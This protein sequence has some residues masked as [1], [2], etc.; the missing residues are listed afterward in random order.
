MDRVVK[1]GLLGAILL[2][3]L[4][5]SP[6]LS[7]A[8]EPWPLVADPLIWMPGSQPVDRLKLT[9]AEQCLKCH[10]DFSPAS[11]PGFAWRGSMMAQA[12]RD[13]LMWAALTVA[14]QDAIWALGNPNAADLCLRCHFP[15]GWLAGRTS[16]SNGSALTGND[17]D[18]ISC[19]LCH[20]MWDP[21]FATAEQASPACDEADPGSA[22]AARL[23]LAADAVEAKKIQLF[24]PADFYLDN[25]PK[26]PASYRENGSGQFYIS[27]N[28]AKRGGVIDAKVA[29]E[30]GHTTLY[31]RYHKSRNFCATCHDVSNSALA[32]LGLSDLPDLSQGEDLLSEQY[33][34][35]NYF[36]I[37]RTFSEFMLSAYGRGR[38]AATNQEF[39]TQGTTDIAWAASCQDCHMPQVSG[40]NANA[41]G[42][43]PVQSKKQ[44]NSG[45]AR[46]ELSGGNSWLPRILASLDPAGPIFDRRNLELLG[47]GPDR[48]TLD[49]RQGLGL[50]GESS[51]LL[52]ASERA[53]EQLRVAA[54]IKE[55]QY[56]PETGALSLRIQNNTGHKLLT[57]FPEGRRMF[58]NLKTYRQGR[59]I[60]EINPYSM[61]AGTLKGLPDAA[62]SPPL[63]KTERYLDELVY[64]VHLRSELT[65]EEQTSHVL[66]AS[67]RSKD[68]RIPPKG[69]D[70]A[71]AATRLSEPVWQGKSATAYFSAA[72]YSGGYDQLQ[73]QLPVGADRVQI[74][75]YYQGVSREYIEFLRDEI[76]GTAGSLRLD[77]KGKN[78]AGGSET[79]TVQ[80]DPFFA[81][82][83]G[84]GDSIWELWHHNHGLTGDRS[85]LPG[86]APLLM[87]QAEW[88]P[89]RSVDGKKRQVQAKD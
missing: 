25:Q 45:P 5:F 26:Y 30:S 50:K 83:K 38:G 75:L 19:D 21:F 82:L 28:T 41:A 3:T 43:R 78:P 9:S 81:Q 1:I 56:L 18:G 33:S 74:S 49:L 14:A 8:W 53:L 15:A 88:S 7:R 59:L 67:S 35:A 72:E 55:L 64:Q 2:A 61:T 27:H 60:D 4:A 13:P 24:D 40:R 86:I 68:N 32:N 62:S 17:F 44:P 63:Q 57:G 80:S 12:G 73:L 6:A 70:R 47:Q 37:E 23:T 89:V 84:W 11:E 69:F 16:P 10:G 20:R 39:R 46:H 87:S 36:H 71:A 77:A 48:L 54:T 42:L 79:Y 51:A 29:A 66:L 34:P 76:N 22:S 65:G 58:L 52:A 31:S 85:P